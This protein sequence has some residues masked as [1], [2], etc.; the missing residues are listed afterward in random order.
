MRSK[1]WIIGTPLSDAEPLAPAAR[2]KLKS[3]S[4]I[5]G[6]SRGRTLFLLKD[7]ANEIGKEVY[8]L[9]PPHPHQR[10][11]IFEGLETA[12]AL[13]K[14]IALFSDTGMPISFDPGGEILDW[15]RKK[16]IEIRSQPAATSWGSAIALSG[17][18]PPFSV[19]GFPPRDKVE[20]DHFFSALKNKGEPIVLLETPYRFLKILQELHEKVGGERELFLA[21]QLAGESERLLWF[22]LKDWKRQI[23]QYGLEKGEFILVLGP[24]PKMAR[25][26]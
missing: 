24:S 10:A 7:L 19:W 25:R 4:V 18:Q 17:Y 6:E 11:A 23:A 21:W 13:G 2:E 1:L 5:V 22:L 3:I 20:R 9:D 26:R 14:D 15:A 16:N 12:A 8:F